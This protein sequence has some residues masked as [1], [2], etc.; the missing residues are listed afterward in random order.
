[1]HVFEM[2]DFHGKLDMI[3]Y[4]IFDGEMMAL[5]DFENENHFSFQR[6][7]LKSTEYSVQSTQVFLT[8]RISAACVIQTFWFQCNDCHKSPL[9]AFIW[10][11]WWLSVYY[12]RNVSKLGRKLHLFVY[13]YSLDDDKWF[14]S[15]NIYICSSR[16]SEL[17]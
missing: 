14:S 15:E 17:Y 5:H 4:M 2:Y 11:Y 13:I 6:A 1:M 7:R 12:D 10:Y 16:A 3:F 9:I 8:Y